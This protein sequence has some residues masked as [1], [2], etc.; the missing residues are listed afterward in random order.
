MQHL[1]SNPFSALSLTSLTTHIQNTVPQSWFNSCKIWP[2]V[3]AFSFAFV[4]LEYRSLVAGVVAIG[5]QTYLS[6]LDQRAKRAERERRLGSGEDMGEEERG[7]GTVD[8]RT[9]ANCAA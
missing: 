7:R 6:L 5:W 3:T 1:L 8:V 9:D 2:A 4:P